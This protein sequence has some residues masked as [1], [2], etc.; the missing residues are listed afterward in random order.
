[1]FLAGMTDKAL[2]HRQGILVIKN[3]VGEYEPVDDKVAQIDS[4]I[5]DKESEIAT[6]KDSNF[7]Q[8][9]RNEIKQ[10]EKQK[11]ELFKDAKK[12]EH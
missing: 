9:R 12:I 10:L 8:A 7:K 2:F 11:Q 3:D 5:E 1:M 4:E 6:S